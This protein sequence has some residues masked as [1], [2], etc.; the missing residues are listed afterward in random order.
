MTNFLKF[1][2]KREMYIPKEKKFFK[3]E[4]TFIS[5]LIILLVIMIAAL[6][7]FTFFVK[8]KELIVPELPNYETLDVGVVDFNDENAKANDLN[9]KKSSSLNVTNT[10]VKDYYKK[11]ILLSNTQVTYLNDNFIISS[12]PST[13]EDAFISVI[14]KN[15]KLKW[16]TKLNDKEYSN[17]KV[18]KTEF[19]NNN[20][21]IAAISEKN[22]NKSLA[23]IQVDLDGKKVSTTKI[24]ENFAG[25]IEDIKISKDFTSIITNSATDVIINIIDTISKE[26]KK[27]LVLSKILATEENI[28]YNASHINDSALSVVVKDYSKYYV[29]DINMENYIT[30]STELTDINNINSSENIYIGNYLNG[31]TAYSSQNIYKLN[32]ANRLIDKF[33]YASIKLED[34]KALK[35]KYKDDES[36]DVNELVN[37]ITI[38]N[39]S[40]EKEKII[41]KSN[42]S[43]SNI[44]DIFDSNLKLEKRFMID[45]INY[46]YENGALLNNFFIDGAI[47]EVYSY[48]FDTPSILISKM[49]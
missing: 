49:G 31:F 33:N 36:I 16:L 14:D 46:Q 39:V 20:Y 29:I 24:K 32:N 2:N 30:K 40:I 45:A 37:T 4:Y 11:G 44:Y 48:G 8:E 10:I 5:I 21:Y 25:R 38:S 35:E 12:G 41:V 6:I 15:G 18:A 7:Y 22:S 28:S 13:E 9:N 27:E 42:T 1:R 23:L 47:Y 26:S 19:Y 3:R 17:I 34:D 43:Y